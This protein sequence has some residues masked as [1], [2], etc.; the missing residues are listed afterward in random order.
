MRWMK[1]LIDIEER[2]LSICSLMSWP[3]NNFEIRSLINLKRKK[4]SRDEI[5]WS[6][7]RTQTLFWVWRLEQSS[8]P[9]K[10]PR[11]SLA[12]KWM[13][14]SIQRRS[15]AISWMTLRGERQVFIKEHQF[16]IIWL[17][18]MQVR[19][20]IRLRQTSMPIQWVQIRRLAQRMGCRRV[21]ISMT[22]K[23]TIW[24]DK[25]YKT[26]RSWTQSCSSQVAV[27]LSLSQL[28]DLLSST[29]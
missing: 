12:F 6:I 13:I 23:F 8:I 21:R 15:K 29:T 11:E 26:R 9:G 24:P 1:I 25:D 20:I 18:S 3:P 14:Q 2:Q 16:L 22:S 4:L 10:M 17:V 27:K 28:I 7:W 5:H 19:C